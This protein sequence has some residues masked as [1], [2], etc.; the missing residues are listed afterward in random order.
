MVVWFE[1]FSSEG[2]LNCGCVMLS[3]L[4]SILKIVINIMS[5][6]KVASCCSVL[7]CE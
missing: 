2:G 6:L 7:E 3:F 5:G 4:L 1:V